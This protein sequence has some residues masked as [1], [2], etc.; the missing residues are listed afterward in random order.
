MLLTRVVVPL[1]LILCAACST[2]DASPRID[3]APGLDADTS[4]P[5]AMPGAKLG[6]LEACDLANDQCDDTM[7]LLCFGFNSKGPHCTHSCTGGGE[8]EAP[9]TGCSGMN[10]CKVP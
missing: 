8:C 3:A 7:N 9:S 10:V 1:S 4:A 2:D 5:D 6:F